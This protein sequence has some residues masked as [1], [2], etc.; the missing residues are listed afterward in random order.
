V[1]DTNRNLG[2]LKVAFEGDGGATMTFK[3]DEAQRLLELLPKGHFLL[4]KIDNPEDLRQLAKE[5]PGELLRRLFTSLKRSL[6]TAEIKAML[7]GVVETKSW[8]RWWNK[9]KNDPRLTVGTGTRP[10]CTWSDSAEAAEKAIVKEFKAAAPRDRLSLAQKHAKRSSE[11]AALMERQLAESA[12]EIGEQDPA[13]ALEMLLARQRLVEDK[14]SNDAQTQLEQLLLR[15]DIVELLCNVE[16]RASRR[17][18]ILLLRDKRQD[19]AERSLDLLRC[20]TDNQLI[21]LLYDAA[22]QADESSLMRLVQEILSRPAE[23]PSFYVWLCREMTSREELKERASWTF[24][25]GLF[26]A[27]GDD[28]LKA[29]QNAL[30]K[31]FDG[32]GVVDRVVDRLEV[33]HVEQMIE[34][35]N[36]AP[37]EDY[38]KDSLHQDLL[39]RFPELRE[40]PEGLFY[41]TAGA[42]ERKREEFERLISQEIP[43]AAEAIKKAK[44][45]G[46]LRENFEYHA[47]RARQE[48][49]SSRAKT[50]HDQL[51]LAR[52][53][54]PSTVDTGAIAAGTRIILQPQ[55]DADERLELIILGPWDSDPS[56]NTLSY[57]APAAAAL[58]GKKAGEQI[59]FNSR[60][61]VIEEIHCWE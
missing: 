7:S 52:A 9:A 33:S 21:A 12:R 44:E 11:L 24:L 13:L 49:L 4:E 19:W 10:V 6:T 37:L 31:M 55:G 26:A 30:R 18:G 20:T 59:S 8:S 25:Q 56:S 29:H 32:G 3:I 5:D 16:D 41:V 57:T 53:I 23:N 50:L 47:A 58:L 40:Q 14:E 1:T 54:D 35:L 17:Q 61:Y 48:M 46:D 60:E 43:A 27:L 42:L 39:K 45:Y 36:R 15:E 28:N 22:L 2:S 34:L 38:R 51:T